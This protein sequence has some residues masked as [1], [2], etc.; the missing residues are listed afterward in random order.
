M[1]RISEKFV[2]LQPRFGNMLGGTLIQLTGNNVRFDEQTT[3]T[4]LFDNEEV[5]AL[6]IGNHDLQ[7]I[8]CVS[9]LLQRIGRVN[10]ALNCSNNYTQQDILANDIFYSCKFICVQIHT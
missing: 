3:Y 2:I 1:L 7:L 5:E 10:F 8:L 4:C 9:P 6:Y